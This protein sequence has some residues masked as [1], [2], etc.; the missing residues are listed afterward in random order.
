MQTETVSDGGVHATELPQSMVA[1]RLAMGLGIAL[2]GVIVAAGLVAIRPD[3]S[4]AARSM[5]AMP[6]MG[7]P[8]RA[9]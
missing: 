6:S 4:R 3:S 7:S 1:L 5:S 8:R 2:L 9:Q